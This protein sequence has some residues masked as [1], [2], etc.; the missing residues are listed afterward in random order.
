MSVCMYVPILVILGRTR[1]SRHFRPFFDVD[2]EVYSDVI[3]GMKAH[4]KLF[5]ESRSNHYRD[6]RLPHFFTNDN[7]DDD[8]TNSYRQNY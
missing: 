8:E 1:Q 3:S 6:I 2:P 7:D 5:D 4:V